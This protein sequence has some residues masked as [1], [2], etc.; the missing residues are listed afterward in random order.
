MNT[1]AHRSPDAALSRLGGGVSSK[2]AQ[3]VKDSNAQQRAHWEQML[4]TAPDWALKELGLNNPAGRKRLK[5]DKEL[6]EKMIDM[7]L[8]ETRS[9]TLEGNMLMEKE[10]YSIAWGYLPPPELWSRHPDFQKFRLLY[11]DKQF[12][13]AL[14]KRVNVV[15]S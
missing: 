14:K 9:G 1:E 8:K 7:F 12:S 4:D 13:P 2:W 6:R 5:E 3:Q 11:T 10:W 15:S